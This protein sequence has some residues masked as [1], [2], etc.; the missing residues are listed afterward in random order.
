MASTL[1]KRIV[2]QLASQIVVWLRTWASG[3]MKRAGR[4]PS[5]AQRLPLAKAHQRTPLSHSTAFYTLEGSERCVA[6]IRAIADDF[7][8]KAGAHLSKSLLEYIEVGQPLAYYA[9]ELKRRGWKEAIV[10][11]PHDGVAHINAA[12]HTGARRGVPLLGRFLRPGH[13]LSLTRGPGALAG[14][15]EGARERDARTAHVVPL[16][17]A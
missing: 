8:S 10:C 16:S 2:E 11:L 3:S 14:G 5:T 12:T 15:P 9:G 13:W 17:M 1:V 4:A 6:R 7:P